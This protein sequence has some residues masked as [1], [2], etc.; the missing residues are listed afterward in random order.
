MIR[1]I[2]YDNLDELVY[3]LVWT[4]IRNE[5]Y[6]LANECLEEYLNYLEFLDTYVSRIHIENNSVSKSSN[7][8]SQLSFNSR[9][10]VLSSRF[11]AISNLIIVKNHLFDFENALA[12]YNKA[13]DL[14]DICKISNL[15]FFMF[16]I[17]HLISKGFRKYFFNF[18]IFLHE[19][20]FFKKGLSETIFCDLIQFKILSC[21]FQKISVFF[22]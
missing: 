16:L 11:Y 13:L 22:N 14:L 12:L 4:L 3:K 1:L 7:S 21:R 2:Y 8:K 6:E 15:N 18:H 20:L 19:E 10:L 17:K 9:D 5:R